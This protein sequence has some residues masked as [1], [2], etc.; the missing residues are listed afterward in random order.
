M[1]ILYDYVN[2]G[3]A[4]I[5]VCLPHGNDHLRRAVTD[6]Q[7]GFDNDLPVCNYIIGYLIYNFM[8][9]V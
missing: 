2:P 6:D 7:D 9:S 4:P 5:P 8:L 1:L 3:N